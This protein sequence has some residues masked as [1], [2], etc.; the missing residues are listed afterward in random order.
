MDLKN[1]FPGLPAARIQAL[2]RTLGYPD[3][4]SSLLSGVCT[5]S[6]PLDVW[7]NRPDS[8]PF[9]DWQDARL[10]YTAPHLPQGAP[11]SPALANITAYRLDCRLSALAKAADAVYTRYADDIAFSGGEEFRRRV[12]RFPRHVAAIVMEEGFQIN[13]YK[14]R[15]MQRGGR[16]HLAGLIVN[17]KPAVPRRYYEQLEAILTNCIRHGPRSQNRE[18]VPDF[19]AHLEGRIGFVAMVN[20]DK[21][22]RLKT[23]FTSIDWDH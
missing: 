22:V 19:R 10:L 14:T 7:R 16:Q 2:F 12:T 8:I 23:L 17:E 11:T 15:I 5:S 21:A 6:V 1:F 13:H 9:S 4:V 20:R 3:K 18:D